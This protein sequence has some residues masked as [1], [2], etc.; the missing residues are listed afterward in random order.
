M[1]FFANLS[2]FRKL[3]AAFAMLIAVM[4]IA[5]TTVYLKIDYIREDTG[6]TTHT[7]V[8]LEKLNLAMAAMV[9]QEVG[10]RGLPGVGLREPL[11]TSK[12]A[13]SVKPSRGASCGGVGGAA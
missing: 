11:L 9:D 2:I 1:S 13:L 4:T 8:V 12:P 3:T 7:Y 5:S 6:W 10:V